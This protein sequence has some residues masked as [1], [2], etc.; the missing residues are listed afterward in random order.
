MSVVQIRGRSLRNRALP[1]R[2]WVFLDAEFCDRL[3]NNIGTRR[4]QNYELIGMEGHSQPFL[5]GKSAASTE[6]VQNLRAGGQSLQVIA[7]VGMSLQG[8]NT[9]IDA[10]A[11]D[12]I[13]RAI[14]QGTHQGCSVGSAQVGQLLP[15][16]AAGQPLDCCRRRGTELDGGLVKDAAKAET[17]HNVWL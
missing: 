16:I 3:L 11:S 14:P 13:G 4:V 9:A 10:E 5:P 17:N 2:D 1:R 7:D 8:K 6:L 12:A 15:T